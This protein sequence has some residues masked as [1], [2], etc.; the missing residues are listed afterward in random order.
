MSE[1]LTGFLGRERFHESLGTAPFRFDPREDLVV[2]SG[3]NDPGL[4]VRAHELLLVYQKSHRYAVVVVDAAWEGSPGAAEIRSK[5]TERLTANGWAADACRVIVIDPEL[6][7]WIWQ[8]NVHVARALGFET[9]DEMLDLVAAV[10]GWPEGQEKPSAPK[11]TLETVLRRRKI[12]RSAS[13]YRRIT[14]QVSIKGC[15]DRAFSELLQALHTWFPAV[16]S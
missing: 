14:S 2:A 5:M 1:A 10:S 16:R 12:P 13:L 8:K 6:E 3:D 4:F 9:R 15:R 7:N 11:E